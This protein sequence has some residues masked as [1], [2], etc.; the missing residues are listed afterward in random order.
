LYL[1][2]IR[3]RN[4]ASLEQLLSEQVKRLPGVVRTHT[5]IALS[6]P[7]ETTALDMRTE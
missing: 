5:L 7:K 4:T 2:K 3:V 1:L 6:S